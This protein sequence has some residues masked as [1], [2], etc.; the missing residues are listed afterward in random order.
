MMSLP[1]PPPY[2]PAPTEIFGDNVDLAGA[3]WH[4][5]PTFSEGDIAPT[6]DNQRR[7]VRVYD[8]I[9]QDWREYPYPED[10]S[11]IV[12]AP[13][14]WNDHL[15]LAV[16]SEGDGPHWIL[17]QLHLDSGAFAVYNPCA[18]TVMRD[19]LLTGTP[20]VYATPIGTNRV[21]LCNQETGEL[22]ASLP[23]ET[24]HWSDLLVSPQADYLVLR[25]RNAEFVDRGGPYNL[26]SYK[27]DTRTLR[28]LGFM[29]PDTNAYIST[30]E[31]WLSNTQ[32]LY[33]VQTMG[34]AVRGHGWYYV[35]NV[36]HLGG[37]ETVITSLAEYRET[38]P[39]YEYLT[40]HGIIIRRWDNFEHI[41]CTLDIFDLTA[42]ETYTYTLGYNCSGVYAPDDH[43]YFYVAFDSD[44]AAPASLSVLDID[45]D[46]QTTIL[47]GEIEA[48]E[49]VSP[50][51]RYAAIITDENG[52]IDRNTMEDT[53]FFSWSQTENPMV[54][55]V[56]V[57]R[58]E[59]IYQVPFDGWWRNGDSLYESVLHSTYENGF[60]QVGVVWLDERTGLV[61]RAAAPR[62]EWEHI[63]LRF[64]NGQVVETPIGG[65]AAL[66]VMD[67]E[68]LIIPENA[69]DGTIIYRLYEVETGVTRPLF[70]NPAPDQYQY[71]LRIEET[72]L[73]RLSISLVDQDHSSIGGWISYLFRIG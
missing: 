17:W 41:P 25:G 63:L 32:L 66:I 43:R 46:T 38:P 40:T 65:Y 18:D 3:H 70:I 6:A 11:A 71:T 20:W 13:Q 29:P 14:A 54:S 59:I 16:S 62:H 67:G 23:D 68:G 30:F 61:Q 2:P 26:Y 10:V 31:S 48:L 27:I 57:S 73:L 60:P 42:I 56:D 49:S 5:S 51:G 58:G 33:E 53:Q 72:G 39:R 52:I 45:S 69:E 35:I 19:T 47:E 12:Q 28:Y 64:E 55:F 21:H 34:M 15:F 8:E 37:I 36:A 50:G 22:F 7:V 4:V 24:S 9:S 1:E 44:P